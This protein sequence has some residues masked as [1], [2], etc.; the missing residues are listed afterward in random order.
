M[1]E[2]NCI[3]GKLTLKSPYLWN[4]GSSCKVL[5]DEMRITHQ[6]RS[7]VVNRALSDFGIE[8]SFEKGAMRFREHYCTIT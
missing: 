5:V 4:Q 1:I 2:Y 8:E 6:G 7:E 3:F